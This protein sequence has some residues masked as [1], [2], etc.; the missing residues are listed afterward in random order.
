MRLL[1]IDEV[2]QS[3]RCS[4]STIRRRLNAAREGKSTFPLPIHGDNKRGLWREE[5]VET[6]QESKPELPQIESPAIK[7]RRLKIIHHQLEQL[8][9]KFDGKT[10]P[11]A[12]N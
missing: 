9:I 6:W 11:E 12:S 2:A 7:D 10:N 3:M 8:G 5:D 4:V 1:T